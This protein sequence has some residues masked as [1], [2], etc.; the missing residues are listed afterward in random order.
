MADTEAP[1]IWEDLR[2][3]IDEQRASDAAALLDSLD[4]GEAVYVTSRLDRPREATL[5]GLLPVEQASDLIRRLPYVE[6]VDLLVRIDPQRAAAVLHELHSDERADLLGELE[7]DDAEAILAHLDPEEV[8]EF[9]ELAEYDDEEA[10]G[11]MVKEYLA[12]PSKAT[13]NEVVE[14]IRRHADEYADYDVQYAYV[15]SGVG[16]LT[17][18]LRMRDI[19]LAPGERR[20]SD[21]MI[22]RPKSVLDTTPLDEL[23]DFFDDNEFLGA[24]V[25]DKRDRL[26]GI[27][28]RS[29]V[30]EALSERSEE[31]Y[32]KTQGIVGGE[33]LRSMPVTLRSRRRLS[34]LSI[35]I[36]LNIIAASVIAV[37]QETLE[38]VIALAVFLPIISDMS[39]CSGNQAVAVSMRE[40]SLGVIKPSEALRVW[41]K[42]LSV[43]AINGLVLGILIGAVAFFWKGN[44]WLGGVVGVAL[45]L[46]TLVAVSIGGCVPLVLK[47]FGMDPALASGPIL[48]TVTDMCGFFL[49]L[50]LASAAL[51]QLT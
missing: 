32:R 11:L 17:G 35:N 41:L 20:I 6:A 24:P 7:D 40:L 23:R 30:D 1:P 21:L 44:L 34:W 8:G 25:V 18:V 15:V 42:E 22:R 50:T 13:V 4:G 45:M 33:E 38:A 9:R 19:L 10:G 2:E 36:V 16:R 5:L 12:F 51:A 31:D 43:G 29:A 27:V 14:N 26:V 48:T 37:Y 46:N 28:K 47:R 3:L 39:G 49:V